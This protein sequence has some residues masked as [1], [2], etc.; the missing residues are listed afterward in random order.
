MSNL[1]IVESPA[2]A[3]TIQKY[4]GKGYDVIA[5][6]GHIRDLP[7]SKLGVDVENG[8]QPKYTDMKGKED[9]IKK[10]KEH[11]KKCDHIY[12][13]TDPDREG[14]A[15]SWHIAQ[16]LHLDMDA[17][18][19]VEFNEITRS[20]IQAG[21][22][23]PHKIDLDLVNAQQARRI[24]DRLVGYKLS[25]FL[26]HK[27]RRGL[28]AGRVQSVA[29]RII[30]D[31]EIEIENFKP[32][33]YWNIDANLKPRQSGCAFNAR[34]TAQADG[35]KL[36]VKN[37][38]QADAI[39]AALDGKPYT[40]TRVDKGQRRRQPQPPFIT[41]TLQQDASRALGFSATRTMRAAQRL[42][43]GME[44]HGYGQIGLITY[45]RTDSLRIADE[46]AAAA[47]T[48]IGKTWGENY[49]CNKKRVWKSRSA[50]AA[51]DAHEAIRPTSLALPPAALKGV[52]KRDQLRLYT[53]I[54]NRFIASQM[55]P[56]IAQSTNV[57]L[58]C[59]EFTLKASGLHILFDGFTI[60]QPAKDEKKDEEEAA[61]IPPLKKGDSVLNVKADGN[62]HFTSP[63]PRY[64]EASLIKV[65][66]E[67]GIGRPSTYAPILDTIQKRRYVT[68][69]G[70]Q[71]VPTEIGFKVTDLLKKY[72]DGVINVDFTANLENWLDKIADGHA[73]YTKVITDFY[74][75]FSDELNA[76]N[77]EAS[78]NKKEEAEVSDVVCEK[79]GAKMIVKLGRYGK[80][81]AC[82]NYPDCKNIKPYSLVNG[83][84]EVSDVH[85]DKCGTLMVYRMGPYGRYLKCPNCN[86]NKAIV[87]DTS[88]VC[89]KCHE[90]HMIQRRTKRGRTFYG[91]SRYPAC[92]MALWNEPVD[93]FCKVC[94][95]IMVKKVSR[96]GTETIVCSNPECPTAPK[97]STTKGRRATKKTASKDET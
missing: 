81:L 36:V 49:V 44:V 95:S 89:P 87:I 77:V 65:L 42:Y 67:K 53:L 32:E 9:V 64:T 11:A 25:P 74:K 18:D 29:V 21:M 43:E 27:V 14:E 33:E 83:P 12:L 40:V 15:I 73:T 71:F 10:L 69:E 92:D 3:K 78:K 31:R 7:K 66:E 94:G 38:K 97:K 47:K 34:L 30:R 37:K 26:W 96:D 45:M 60:M 20:G 56:Q 22:S 1:V 79:C 35:T 57:T 28:S 23:H 58:Q 85:C 68:K 82:P 13:A 91:C 61:I 52:L 51:Q 6:M 4:L 88:I 16:M 72:F 19:R 50:T 48:F 80:Y 62:Q 54:W 46:A 84:E 24:L 86:A 59:G 41:S 5:S 63:P 90:G 75:V 76:A 8:F 55:A 70:K 93:Q 39:L 2:K 17:D